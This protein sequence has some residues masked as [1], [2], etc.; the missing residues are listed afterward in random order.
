MSTEVVDEISLQTLPEAEAIAIRYPSYTTQAQNISIKRNEDA[1]FLERSLTQGKYTKYD[2]LAN[3]LFICYGFCLIIWIGYIIYKISINGVIRKFCKEPYYSCD[4]KDDPYTIPCCDREGVHDVCYSR[5]DFQCHSVSKSIAALIAQLFLIIF[6]IF[7]I[8][9][10]YQSAKSGIEI[11]KSSSSTNHKGC[12]NRILCT[13]QQFKQCK[14]KLQSKRINLR[15]CAIPKRQTPQETA[16][17]FLWNSITIM[18][19]LTL[20]AE[21][22]EIIL[23]II[24]NN[25]TLNAVGYA[26]IVRIICMII[27]TFC[28]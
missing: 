26:M 12:K 28:F 22:P 21:A 20:L 5:D 25:K 24:A 11:I 3:S 1:P 15:K 18:A 4:D 27:D 9:I 7:N 6:I 19:F 10:F 8:F 17:D 23:N 2:K 13:Y 14:D 16:V